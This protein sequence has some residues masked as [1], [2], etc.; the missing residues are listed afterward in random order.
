MP[1]HV[2]ERMYRHVIVAHDDDRVSAD[3][4]REEITRLGDLGLDPTKI[5]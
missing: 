2:V 1:A 5:Q 4:D 3:L